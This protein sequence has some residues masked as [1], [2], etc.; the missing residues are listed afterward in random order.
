MSD[1]PAATPEFWNERWAQDQLGFHEGAPNRQLVALWPGLR[2]G[3][4]VLVPLCGKSHDLE[5][6][7]GQ[8][9]EVVG[10]ELS[11]LAC[12]AFFAERGLTPTVTSEGRYTRYR[13]G[14]VTILQGDIFDLEGEFDAL[15][16]RAALIAL[17]APVRVRYAKLVREHVRG[18]M[19]IIAIV[20][21]QQKRDGPP[22]SVPDDEVR[23]LHPDATMVERET[24]DEE[25]W[26]AIGKVENVAWQRLPQG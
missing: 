15:W 8:G 10:V 21:D 16:D 4:R 3:K 23:R 22:F 20:Y 2:A 6:L 7:A 17:P 26:R 19:L 18:A 1:H 13:H 24:V 5:W 9:H 14:A 11:P 25:R 12:A